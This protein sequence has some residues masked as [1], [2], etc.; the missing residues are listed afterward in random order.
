MYIKL[1]PDFD[2]SASVASYSL[3]SHG[4]G[5]LKSFDRVYIIFAQGEQSFSLYLSS[6]SAWTD[7]DP[8]SE[9]DVL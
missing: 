5:C 2:S 4:R 9:A 7:A 3:A 6:L 1:R 8:T